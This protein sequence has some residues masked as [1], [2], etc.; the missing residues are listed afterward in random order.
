MGGGSVGTESGGGGQQAQGDIGQPASAHGAQGMQAP[1]RRLLEAC[2]IEQGMRL[3]LTTKNGFFFIER[4]S[5]LSCLL[6][7]NKFWGIPLCNCLAPR[8]EGLSK[9]GKSI[10]KSRDPQNKFPSIYSGLN[11]GSPCQAVF[12]YF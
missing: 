3:R 11:S 4:I 12:V 6:A 1:I 10:L 7:H 9:L 8:R 2:R 5:L